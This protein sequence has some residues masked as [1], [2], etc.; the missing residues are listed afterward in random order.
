[1]FYPLGVYQFYPLLFKKKKKKSIQKFQS[2]SPLSNSS[3]LITVHQ[4]ISKILTIDSMRYVP[5]SRFLFL[6]RHNLICFKPIIHWN[7]T[8]VTQPHFFSY[9]ESQSSKQSPNVQFKIVLIYTISFSKIVI[10]QVH[11]PSKKSDFVKI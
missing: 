10:Y 1:M 4:I 6:L 11:G 2:F 5:P 7:M 8:L 9:S 3:L